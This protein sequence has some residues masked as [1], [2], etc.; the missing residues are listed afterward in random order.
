MNIRSSNVA[1]ARAANKEASRKKRLLS[2]MGSIR[3]VRRRVGKKCLFLTCSCL[4]HLSRDLSVEHLH[5][6]D[7]ALSTKVVQL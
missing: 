4:T 7:E 5:G 1:R 2:Q 3:R 6:C